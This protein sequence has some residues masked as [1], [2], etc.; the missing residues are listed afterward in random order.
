MPE[1]GTEN[2]WFINICKILLHCLDQ[3][4]LGK[5]KASIRR[6]GFLSKDDIS[7]DMIL[8]KEG[9]RDRVSLYRENK[10]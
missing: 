4:V 7:D 6:Q 10:L 2:S 8:H 1:K 9:R 5:K 3:G